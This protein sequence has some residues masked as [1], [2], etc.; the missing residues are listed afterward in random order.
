MEQVSALFRGFNHLLDEFRIF[1]PLECDSEESEPAQ[2]EDRPP[3]R[4]HGRGPPVAIN[5]APL[6]VTQPAFVP[7]PR[8]T[9]ASDVE[10]AKYFVETVK[11]RQRREK[12]NLVVL[13]RHG[14]V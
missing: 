4:P 10:R 14:C 9:T 12:G 1:L 3:P 6:D 2:V 8:E 11:V 7:P 5:A 13:L